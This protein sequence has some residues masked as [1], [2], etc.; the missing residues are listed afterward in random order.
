MSK[1]DK[2]AMEITAEGGA[3]VTFTLLS[4][5]NG[6]MGFVASCDGDL[7]YGYSNGAVYA[8]SFQLSPPIP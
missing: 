5:S 2:L 7:M 3:T 8:I 1:A 4:W 6:K